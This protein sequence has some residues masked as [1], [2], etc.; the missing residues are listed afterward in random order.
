MHT[1]GD[2]D[3]TATGAVGYDGDEGGGGPIV[4][5]TIGG[6]HS[7]VGCDQQTQYQEDAAGGAQFHAKQVRIASISCC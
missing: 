2:K 3:S 1:P 4:P 6:D 7:S 5:K